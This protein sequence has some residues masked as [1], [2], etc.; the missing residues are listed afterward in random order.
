MSMHEIEDLV[1]ESVRLVLSGTGTREA[2][3]E[4]ASKLYRFQAWFDTSETTGRL[5]KELE[6]I[7]YFDAPEADDPELLPLAAGMM[8]MAD[9]AE[10]LLLV[11]HWLAATTTAVTDL[12]LGSLIPATF[13]AMLAE[14]S[15]TAMRKIA[16]RHGVAG[17]RRKDFFMRLPGWNEVK[18]FYPLLDADTIERRTILRH[19]LDHRATP[20]R[21]EADYEAEKAKIARLGDSALFS[22]PE[23]V[24]AH[25]PLVLLGNE[26]RRNLRMFVFSE[27]ADLPAS[28]EARLFFGIEHDADISLLA[29]EMRIQSGLLATWQG[30]T[31]GNTVA[32]TH[33]RRNFAMVVP[34]EELQ[35]DKDFH[36]FGG[37]KF[38]L[39][40]SA[41]LL[42]KRLQAIFRHWRHVQDAAAFHR[43]PLRELLESAS[44]KAMEENR[45]DLR[46]KHGFF[47]ND[48]E[49][50]FAYACL[51]WEKGRKPDRL[52]SEIRR[53]LDVVHDDYPLKEAWTAGVEKLSSGI[54]F[55][56]MT[57]IFP[58]RAITKDEADA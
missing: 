18:S 2:K 42:E 39:D 51:E 46:D 54:H 12:A 24:P 50:L 23:R 36:A 48:I 44:P 49:L 20:E 29:C 21:I 14:G 47:V 25:A 5:R 41:K 26:R 22:L 52:I 27:R 31:E 13:E 35:K 8:K 4:T 28:D 30:L 9:E 55:P 40:Q 19:L 58:Y 11:H 15:G 1:E 16:I 33:F 6:E 10:D 32:D 57:Q 56:P 34:D 3:V 17:S 45:R 7:G 37:W 38:R 43:K 53:K